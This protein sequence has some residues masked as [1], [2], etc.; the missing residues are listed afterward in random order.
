MS[1]KKARDVGIP[2]V[3]LFGQPGSGKG[4]RAPFVAEYLGVP[5]LTTGDLLRAAVAA[6]SPIAMSSAAAMDAGILVNDMYVV[7][8]VVERL[9]RPDCAKGFVLDGFP[10]TLLQAQMLDDAI[11]PNRVNL[12][13]ALHVKTDTLV[14]RVCGR[15]VHQSTGRTYH[16]KFNAPKSLG[17]REPSPETMLDD[18]TNEPLMQ[19]ADDT[20]AALKNRLAAY[21]SQT[22]PVLEHYKS[23]IIWIDGNHNSDTKRFLKTQVDLILIKHYPPPPKSCCVVC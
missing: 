17:D 18:E 13:I 21:H 15:W 1:Q 4:A 22:V 6:D 9:K 11:R 20:D 3:V 23:S 8:I 2:V 7:S 10:R 19:R 12:V 5:L 14:A 16:A